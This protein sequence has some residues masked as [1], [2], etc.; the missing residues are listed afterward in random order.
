MSKLLNKIKSSKGEP[1]SAS[2]ILWISITIAVVLILAS[3]ILPPLI[4]NFDLIEDE[5][6]TSGSLLG[7]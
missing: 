7:G 1:V 3:L 5:I 4:A 2:M 6:S